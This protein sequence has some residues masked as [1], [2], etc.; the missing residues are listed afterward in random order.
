MVYIFLLSSIQLMLTETIN[1]MAS[2]KKSSEKRKSKSLKGSTLSKKNLSEIRG[3]K[4]V[5]KNLNEEKDL[6]EKKARKL[7]EKK[8]KKSKLKKLKELLTKLLK[9]EKSVKAKISKL[10]SADGSKKEKAKVKKK[11]DSSNNNKGKS[12]DK[13]RANVKEEEIVVDE[14][15]VFDVKDDK[16]ESQK[17]A[18]KL[19]IGEALHLSKSTGLSAREAISR[20]RK[21][22]RPEKVEEF[23][24]SEKRITV[25]RAADA[26]KRKLNP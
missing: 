6:L 1:N 4:K 3:L 8:A 21:L 13:I 2:Q 10:K 12:K 14:S 22:D 23:I 5:K 9:K 20:I 7:K 17:R 16:D 26:Q 24:S 15:L 19:D 25:I 11:P 18:P